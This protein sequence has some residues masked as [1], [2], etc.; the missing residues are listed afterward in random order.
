MAH[1]TGVN[2]GTVN[3]GKQHCKRKE[4][5]GMETSVW[6]L[7]GS[8]CFWSAFWGWT[9]A[10][11]TKMLCGLAQ[12]RRLDFSY[13]VSTGGMPSAHTAMV[14]SLATAVGLQAGF[15]SALFVVTMA[16]ALVVM[17][18]ASTVRRAAGQQAR[19]LNQIVDEL[20]QEHHLSEKK[21]AELLGHTRLEVFMGMLVGILTALIVTS[22]AAWF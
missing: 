12:T 11:G 1:A 20:F 21:L 2:A 13:M 9:V 22:S 3:P 6:D 16:F 17:F 8:V 7:F 19:L 4:E 14:T 18:D 5:G 10:Q 15:G